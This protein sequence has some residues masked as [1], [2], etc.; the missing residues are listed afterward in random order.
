M[1]SLQQHTKAVLAQVRQAYRQ[2]TVLKALKTGRNRTI[3]NRLKT[4]IPSTH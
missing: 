1:H 4:N 2:C 3:E